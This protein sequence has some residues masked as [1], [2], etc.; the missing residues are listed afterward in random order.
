MV[1]LPMKEPLKQFSHL[2]PPSFFRALVGRLVLFILFVGS[3]TLVWW[4]V[5]RLAPLNKDLQEISREFN[6]LANEVEQV[7]LKWNEANAEEIAVAQLQRA[8]EQLFVG[9]E[10]FPEWHKEVKRQS[11][12]AALDVNSQL[13]KA[14]ASPTL[15]KKVAIT[16]AMIDIQPAAV[17]RSTNAPYKR[18]LSFVQGLATQKR[19]ADLVELTVSGHSNSVT[20]AKAV[21]QLWSLVEKP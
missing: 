12:P 6:R 5:N 19:R 14:H 9:T 8:Q 18:L 4:S 16:P 11:V 1:D 7:D 13:G 21:F 3:V 10:D 15:E 17:H 20:Q 2:A